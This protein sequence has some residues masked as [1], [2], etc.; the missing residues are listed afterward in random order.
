MHTENESLFAA[1]LAAGIKYASHATDLYLPDTAEVRAILA[2]FPL[3]ERNA[4][5]FTNQVEGGIWIDVPFAYL[6]AWEAKQRETAT[7]D[8]LANLEFKITF[9][10]T[11]L[12][13]LASEPDSEEK[14]RNVATNVA[15]IA[16]AKAEIERLKGGAL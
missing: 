15:G 4:T 2:S 9:S 3:N 1:V 14:R 10:E 12:R 13:Y 7:T 6:P 8:K 16:E 5:R 11:N